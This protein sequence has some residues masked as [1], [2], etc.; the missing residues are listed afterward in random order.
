MFF[1]LSGFLITLLLL[2]EQALHGRIGGLAFYRRRAMRL[3]PALAVVIVVTAL[4]AHVTH[5]WPKTE[6]PSILSVSFYYSNY[7][8]AASPNAYC[9]NLS[10]GIPTLV[11]AIVRGAVLSRVAVGHDRPT[12]YSH[13]A[14][15]RGCRAS[16]VDRAGR[17]TP[18]P[19]LPRDRIVV[20]LVPPYRHP[21]RRDPVGRSSGPPLGQGERAQARR[22][23]SRHGS[24]PFFCSYACPS[25]I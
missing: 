25:P 13:P 2:R 3:L 11:V 6:V 10:A 18:R 20:C 16:V 7:Y 9:A 8:L 15:H 4:V 22:A 19:L 24:R 23:A 5:R 1:V 14:S 21:S 17:D 12:Y